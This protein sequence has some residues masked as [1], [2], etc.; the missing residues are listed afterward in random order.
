MD[1]DHLP[2]AD[3]TKMDFDGAATGAK[4]WK[5]IWGAGQGIGAV[6]KVVPVSELVGRLTDE[7]KAAKARVCG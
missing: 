1:P 7:Y 4:A 3:P 6:K 5:D 2:V